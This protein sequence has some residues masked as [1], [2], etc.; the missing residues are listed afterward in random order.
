MA[1]FIYSTS[2][3]IARK[4]FNNIRDAASVKAK[5]GRLLQTFKAIKKLEDWTGNGCQDPDV[6]ER[7]TAARKDSVDLP[8]FF[9]V[10][11]YKQF[12]ETQTWYDLF[13]YRLVF[14]L[15]SG[16]LLTYI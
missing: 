7:I 15:L 4:E 12:K 2:L 6:E 9:T 16:C 10:K 1:V 14:S 11:H 3:Q 8:D 5:Y 13:D